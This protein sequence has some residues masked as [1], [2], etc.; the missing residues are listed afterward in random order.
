M[1][2]EMRAIKL[3]QEGQCLVK[4][5]RRHGV[6]WLLADGEISSATAEKILTRPDIEALGDGLFIGLSQSY[7]LTGPSS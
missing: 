6:K 1:I 4:L 3:M 2:T 5:N 7:R